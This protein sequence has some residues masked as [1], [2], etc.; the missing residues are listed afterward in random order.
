MQVPLVDFLEENISSMCL[1]NNMECTT[2]QGGGGSGLDVYTVIT[3]CCVCLYPRKAN[4]VRF[5][6]KP[7]ADKTAG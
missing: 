7:Q 5:D 6:G 1:K 4:Q 3:A 2:A